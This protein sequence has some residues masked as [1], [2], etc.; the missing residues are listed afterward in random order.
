MVSM[1]LQMDFF[2][3]STRGTDEMVKTITKVGLAVD[4]KKK[5]GPTDNGT[6]I[7][8]NSWMRFV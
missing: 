6:R 2:V 4:K 7:A 5:A 8:N 3:K 1:K